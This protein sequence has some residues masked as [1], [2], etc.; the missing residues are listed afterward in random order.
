MGEPALSRILPQDEREARSSPRKASAGHPLSGAPV[1]ASPTAGPAPAYV[2]PGSA[3]PSAIGSLN[4]TGEFNS[5]KARL[6]QAEQLLAMEAEIRGLKSRAELNYFAANEFSKSTGAAQ[7]LVHL[8]ARSHSAGSIIA[9]KGLA[10]PDPN[11]P[12][13]RW[14]QSEIDITMRA[15]KAV[16]SDELAQDEAQAKPFQYRLN[17]ATAPGG[18][19][20]TPCVLTIPLLHPGSAA[21]LGAVSYLSRRTLEPGAVALAGRQCSVLAHSLA[22]FAPRRA[23]LL[24]G[25]GRMISLTAILILTLVMLIPV[26]MRVLAPASIQPVNPEIVAA[27][28]SG[29]IETIH[30]GPNEQVR[31]GDILLSFNAIELRNQRDLAEKAVTIAE[32]RYKRASQDAFS[33]GDARRELAIAK[34]ELDLALIE[35]NAARQRLERVQVRAGT[36]GIVLYSGKEKWV[37]RPVSTGERIMR[38][39]DASQ[40]QFEIDLAVEDNIALPENARVNV[41]LDSDP[42]DP[43]AAHLTRKSY[44]AEMSEDGRLVFRLKAEPLERE[45]DKLRLGLHGTAQLHGE[46]VPLWLFLFRKPVAFLRQTF[47]L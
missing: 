3:H 5:L 31:T 30:V 44:E 27:P 18:E 34:A 2:R 1:S 35:R 6:T 24:A 9:V 23:G 46:T 42:L 39:S 33:A 19:F 41:F 7:V 37:G 17:P 8:P 21:R 11:A 16:L 38:I 22:A 12:L 14:L 43:V 36:D 15:R 45:G 20:A 28:I 29:V 25:K 13:M 40:M 10:S 32:A 26:S 4:R 47:G